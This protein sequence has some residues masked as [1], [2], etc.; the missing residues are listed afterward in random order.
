MDPTFEKM[1][2][3][4]TALADVSAIPGRESTGIARTETS[5][6]NNAE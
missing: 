5:A 3:L 2:A 6:I 4:S 1:F